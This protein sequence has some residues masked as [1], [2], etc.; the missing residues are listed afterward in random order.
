MLTQRKIKITE[1][2]GN[3]IVDFDHAN[4]TEA[5]KVLTQLLLLSFLSTKKGQL[6]QK[7]S[8]LALAIPSTEVFNGIFI[9]A[10]QTHLHFDEKGNFDGFLIK[11]KLE[12]INLITEHTTPQKNIAVIKGYAGDKSD[13]EATLQNQFNKYG[14]LNGIS[15][16]LETNRDKE[17]PNILK[18]TALANSSKRVD[19][20]TMSD[21]Q[22]TLAE[23][24]ILDRVSAALKA[25]ESTQPLSQIITTHIERLKPTKE[26]A[27]K[28]RGSQ[29]QSN[30]LLRTCL[31]ITWFL[32]NG[33]RQLTKLETLEK[34]SKHLQQNPEQ[35][36]EAALEA[37]AE[38]GKLSQTKSALFAGR[39]SRIARDLATKPSPALNSVTVRH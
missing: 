18:V 4:P 28:I 9:N 2:N 21:I 30:L 16:E 20:V 14:Q 36:F 33:N 8:R 1:L 25:K 23:K 10:H 38:P 27:N 35:N 24:K 6:V 26:L 13:L 3:L 32:S 7:S 12:E 37:V 31:N 17:I 15:S 5:E 34:M 39:F 29:A 11:H 19:S 22:E